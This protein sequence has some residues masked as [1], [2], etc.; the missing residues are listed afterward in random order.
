MGEC[1]C[2]LCDVTLHLR[3]DALSG[4]Q[5]HGKGR[6]KVKADSR[7]SVVPSGLREGDGG[8]PAVEN[9]SAL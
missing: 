7:L 6:K 9:S 2:L 5:C 8:C 3:K 4:C 1:A